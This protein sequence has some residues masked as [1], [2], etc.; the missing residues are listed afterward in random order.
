[1]KR[2]VLLG[3]LVA[4]LVVPCSAN[5]VFQMTATQNALQVGQEA[6]IGIWAKADEASGLNGLNVWQLD[7]VTNLD[8]V[9]EV[10][11]APDPVISLIAPAPYDATGSGWGSVNS[12]SSGNVLEL[13]MSTVNNGQDSDTGV[14]V[15]S[16]LAEITIV[17]IGNVGDEVTYD[18]IDNGTLG[19]YG[20]L[21]DGTYYDIG[22]GNLSFDSSNNNNVFTIV[23]PEPGSLT[24]LAVMSGLAMRRRRQ[25]KV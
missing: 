9:V 10:K 5:L 8:G 21:K 3:V 6:T 13:G 22:M 24:I 18:L 1:M 16:L 11:T 23:A 15:L 2:I 4:F 20:I 17:A 25:L 12:P 14:G 7:M 19:F